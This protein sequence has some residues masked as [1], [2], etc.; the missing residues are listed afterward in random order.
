MKEIYTNRKGNVQKATWY[1]I[2][3]ASAGADSIH[4]EIDRGVHASHR[5]IVEHGFTEK[6]LRAAETFLVANVNTLCDIIEKSP[7]TATD[8]EEDKNGEWS[9]PFN[10]SQWSTYLNYD[11]MGDLVFGRRFNCMTSDEH[12]FVPGLIMNATI[13]IYTVSPNTR[14]P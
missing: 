9:Q 7:K 2:I 1:G 8:S 5:R 13:F 6:A 14:A 4:A 12:R 11:I 3:E 10:F